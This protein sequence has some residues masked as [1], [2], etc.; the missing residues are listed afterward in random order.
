MSPGRSVDAFVSWIARSLW[1]LLAAIPGSNGFEY[2]RVAAATLRR[3][4]PLDDIEQRL[5]LLLDFQVHARRVLVA[6]LP[7]ERPLRALRRTVR[8]AFSIAARGALPELDLTLSPR[9]RDQVEEFL[10]L[11]VPG[12]RPLLP[13]EVRRRVDPDHQAACP[14]GPSFREQR[15]QLL[16]KPWCQLRR[17]AAPSFS[18]ATFAIS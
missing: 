13:L 17:L 15:E 1:S 6:K 4:Y 10:V 16:L 5:Q 18:L 11:L 2:F 14:D 9:S 12:F 8:L 3:T 7:L